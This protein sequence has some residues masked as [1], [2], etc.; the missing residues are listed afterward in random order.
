[1][2][3]KFLKKKL[4]VHQIHQLLY[5]T[6]FF[7]INNLIKL[8]FKD[9]IYL[10]GLQR[11]GTHYIKKI[12]ENHNIFF[13]NHFDIY[14]NNF[15]N[16]HFRWNFFNPD[17]SVSQFEKYYI[18][19]KF[20]KKNNDFFFINHFGKNS[21]HLFIFKEIDNWLISIYEYLRYNSVEIYERDNFYRKLIYEYKNFFFLFIK[22]KKKYPKNIVL[23]R[24]ESLKFER[25]RSNNLLNEFLRF[26]NKRISIFDIPRTQIK[27]SK[28]ILK[29]SDNEG[30]KN[31]IL[32]NKKK[33]LDKFNKLIKR[34]EEY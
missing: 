20:N 26:K 4:I 23:I 27:G 12:L 22:L 11:S 16:I 24:Y 32:E 21:R 29:Y 10:H 7:I 15:D 9:K 33:D 13:S 30:W 1:M 25:K 28:R 3:I 31:F 6:F 2:I 14:R 18:K 5:F 17:K 34:Y 8:I 19:K